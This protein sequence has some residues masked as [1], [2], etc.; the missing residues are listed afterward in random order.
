MAERRSVISKPPT[1]G[2]VNLP[3]EG[4]GNMFDSFLAGL[5]GDQLPGDASS[6][7]GAMAPML[8]IAKLMKM[9]GKGRGVS[10]VGP[11][12]ATGDKMLREH[13]F[14]SHKMREFL[15]VGEEGAH[16]KVVSGTVGADP[17]EAAYQT[18]LNGK[19]RVKPSP[20]GSGGGVKHEEPANV[21]WPTEEDLNRLKSKLRKPQNPNEPETLTLD[22][23][24]RAADWESNPQRPDISELIADIQ[25]NG[26]KTPLTMY[27]D[28]T[29]GLMLVDGH[30]RARAAAQLGLKDVPVQ[31]Q[32]EMGNVKR[33]K[34][35]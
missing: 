24:L 7:L 16:M 35:K 23:V 2:P 14:D 25:R 5:L 8:P 3:Q 31:W 12:T 13:V 17:Q 10:A 30:H 27:Q 15:P 1:A 26:I 32:D 22:K 33:R 11:A 34:P 4:P 20:A 18:I 6:A 19:G 28:P 29:M 21:Q 9:L